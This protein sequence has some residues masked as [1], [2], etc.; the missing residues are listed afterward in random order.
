MRPSLTLKYQSE[1][2]LIWSIF[3]APNTELDVAGYNIYRTTDPD[4]PKSK[5]TLLNSAL[6]TKM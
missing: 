3:F 4:L 6:L 5:W 2:S 1:I